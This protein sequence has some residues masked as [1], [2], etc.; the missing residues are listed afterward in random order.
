[1]PQQ[2][3]DP[4][5]PL[6]QLGSLLWYGFDTWPGDVHWPVAEAKKN[7]SCEFFGF[8]ERIKVRFTLCYRPLRV[9]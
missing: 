1:M 8:P 5:L 9:Q 7:Q 4:V 3:K 2:V 6:Q